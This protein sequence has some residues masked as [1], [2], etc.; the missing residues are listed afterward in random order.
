MYICAAGH[1]QKRSGRG[2]RGRTCTLPGPPFG[3]DDECGEPIRT[4]LDHEE[5]AYLLGGEE[6]ILYRGWQPAFGELPNVDTAHGD[7]LD[8]L[9]YGVFGIKR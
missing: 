2:P 4:L 8:A 5:A 6:A 9:A 3:K 1:V 7:Q